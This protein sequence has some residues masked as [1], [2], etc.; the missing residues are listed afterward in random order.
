MGFLYWN[1][2]VEFWK[3]SLQTKES[4]GQLDWV[5]DGSVDLKGRPVL[6][7][8]S[9]GWKA[10]LFIIGV[11]VSE[12]L[13]YYGIAS[14][15]II[16]LTTTM[17]EG[18][19]VSAKNVN[20][21]VGVT[22]VMPLVGGFVADAYSGRYWMVLVSSVI[23]LAGLILLTLSVSLSALKPEKCVEVCNKAT[24]GEKAVFFLA[25]YL[26]AVGTGGHK[27][28]LQ[29]FGADQFNEE[30]KKEKIK[31]ASFFNWWYFGLCSGTLLAVTVVVYVQDNISWGIGFGIPTVAMTI[32]IGLF[33]YGTP[34]Y[35]NKL[36]G[37]SPITSILQVV[38]AAVRN[39]KKTL[40][41]DM[42]LLYENWNAK[43]VKSGQR[44][45]SH[46]DSI[47]CLD[48]AAIVVEAYEPNNHTEGNK[49]PN[50]WK[51]CTVTQVEETK[52]IIRMVPIWLCCIIFGIIVAQT[53]TFFIKQGS[54]MDRSMG[55]HFQI[56][57]ASLIAFST[58]PILI[59]ISIYDTWLVPI[60]KRITGNERG[61]SVLQR[62]GI[63]MLFSILCMVS[64]A[65]TE[66]KRI[67]SAKA[68]SLL[69][70]PKTTLPLSIFWLVPQFVLI[71]MADVFTLVGLQE[72]FYDQ[73][74]D[75]M[76]SL[77]IAFYL[78]VIGVASFLSSLL[79]TIVDKITTRGGRD[80]GWFQNNL[81]RCK[82]EY[83]Y[84]L[85]AVLG[86]IN[87]CCYVYIANIYTYKE[88]KQVTYK[89]VK[90]I[91]LHTTKSTGSCSP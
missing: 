85:L 59:F 78:S 11:E 32:A 18:I 72:Y 26:I 31:K 69:D 61:I 28:S 90:Q 42:D 58:I 15:L 47:Q 43:S 29:A 53:T 49:Q 10:S 40:P 1:E 62:I 4:G 71:G 74:P 76:R 83:F 34:F 56:P 91:K 81:N 9:G 86:A 88:V 54:T 23:Y 19:E 44:L 12:R 79:I 5:K 80:H 27:P 67:Q 89:E 21:W 65:L 6:K 82:L 24:T 14:N 57:S 87:L 84:W 25:L 52:L 30:D 63:G 68:H 7:T 45:L 36:P 16:Y 46:T 22:T 75:S 3:T 73:V 33:L 38:V 35:R 48:K 51:L 60:T 70:S 8:K 55:P 41:S 77:G 66:H 17:H 13:T 50:P 39:R 37:G 64:A 2:W 20:Y